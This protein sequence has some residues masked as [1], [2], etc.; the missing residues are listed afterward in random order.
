ME[1]EYIG[2]HL[3]WGYAGRFALF[4]AF[5]S[6]IFAGFAYFLAASENRSDF[7]QW[8]CWARKAFTIHSIMVFTAS[9]ALM[10]VLLNHYY[11]YRYVWIHMENDLAL[12]YKIA[13]FWAGQEGSLLFWALAQVFFGLLIIRRE[14]TWESPV[15]AVFSLSQVFMISMLLGLR[16]GGLRIGFDPFMLL[17][18]APENLGNHFF[19]NPEYLKLIT[20]GNGLNP[21]LRNFWMMSHPPVTFIGYAAVLVPYCFAVAGLWKRKYHEWITPAMPWTILGVL[22]LGAG[23][24]LGGVWAYESLTFGGFW[25]WDPI[26]NASLVPWLI[27]VAALHLMVVSEKKR[28]SYFPG[29]LFIT[30]AFVFVIYATYLTRSGVLSETSVHSFGSDGMGRHILIYLFSFLILALVLLFRNNRYLP[31]KTNEQVFKRE[32]WLF[33]AALVLVL[34]AFQIIF[35]TSIPVINKAFGTGLTPPVDVVAYYNRWQLPFAVV[36]ALLM[37]VSHFIRWGHNHIRKFLLN[38]SFAAGL[39]VVTSLL[40]VLFYGIS[41]VPYTLMLIASSFALFSSLDMLFRFRRLMPGTGA[42]ISHLGMA[43]MLLAIL[44]T[45][46]QKNTI[47]KNTSGYMLGNQFSETENLL[48]IKGEIMPM[49]EFYVTYAGREFDGERF[50][51]Q[52]DFL[53]KN[54]SG[55]FYKVFSSFPTVLLNERMGNV[56]EPFAKIFPFRDLFTYITFADLSEI[57]PQG[58]LEL[59]NEI[60]IAINDTLTFDNN[61]LILRG[62][63]TGAPETDDDDIVL[64]ANLEVLTHFGK[65]YYA[66]PVMIVSDGYLLHRDATVRDL[67]ITF[68]FKRVSDE[69]Y[70]IV[71]GV[72]EEQPEFIIIKTIIFPL[73]NLLWIS[74]II[75]MIGLWMA[76]RDRRRKLIKTGKK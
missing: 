34:S 29:F 58:T 26:E 48:L 38:M 66:D 63:D 15:M 60:S 57:K 45:F 75:M 3:F 61:S 27:L 1:I 24:L 30:L 52:V 18:L 49:G 32:F 37:G 7:R 41:G 22:F 65:S 19:H 53:K 5:F 55:D 44:L 8:R 10:F 11:E 69:A 23:I 42:T 62:I 39:A 14:R 73:I 54:Q 28:H 20:D 64:T 31:S 51:Y 70:T 13:A 40:F 76:Y 9:F 67:D 16:F 74:I 59:T 43:L 35:S 6:A 2:E 12:G 17:R 56:Y 33:V 25:A 71:I 68:R 72:Y 47:S 36:I 46:S 4:V 21:L 50:R